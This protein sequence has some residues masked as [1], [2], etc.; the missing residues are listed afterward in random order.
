[1]E[2][3]S[4]GKQP[5]APP[6]QKK[7]TKKPTKTKT[8]PNQTKPTKNKKNCSKHAAF[9]EETKTKMLKTYRVDRLQPITDQTLTRTCITIHRHTY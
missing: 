4:K 2:D 6:P 8:K 7:Q 5:D 3:K 1:M 9:L